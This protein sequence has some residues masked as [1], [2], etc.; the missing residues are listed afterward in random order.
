MHPISLVDH[1]STTAAYRLAA[2]ATVSFCK[3][4]LQ[5]HRERA[6][7]DDVVRDA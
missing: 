4:D 1:R 5:A 7:R 3:Q 6:A 2:H